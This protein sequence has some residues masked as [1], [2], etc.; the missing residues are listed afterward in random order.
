MKKTGSDLRLIANHP[1]FQFEEDFF[2]SLFFNFLP[3]IPIHFY[4]DQARLLDSVRLL[5]FPNAESTRIR[6]FRSHV[7]M[8]RSSPIRRQK[9]RTWHIFADRA[10]HFSKVR[11]EHRPKTSASTTVCQCLSN[12]LLLWN[13]FGKTFPIFECPAR[14]DLRILF[15]FWSPNLILQQLTCFFENHV[16]NVSRE[17][18]IVIETR[19]FSFYN[20]A[21][22][23]ILRSFSPC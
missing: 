7:P 1:V 19:C 20:L 17:T 6:H 4:Q 22:N 14:K 3:L 13:T 8:L 2:H 5:S 23:H 18:L 15:S 9:L 10:L 12:L 11:G 21:I 16:L